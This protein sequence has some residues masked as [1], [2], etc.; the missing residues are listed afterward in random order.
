MP[1]HSLFEGVYVVEGH[2]YPLSPQMY[3][4]KAVCEREG[5]PFQS[6]VD[7]AEKVI[8]AFEPLTD[9]C[10][11]VLIDIWFVNKRVW[12]AMKGRKLHL[13]K[14]LAS[15]SLLALPTRWSRWCKPWRCAGPWK[16]YLL[17]LKS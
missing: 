15:M 6:K 2:Q 3:R 17:I 5:L 8:Q 12:K 9:T 7:L 16:R 11:H 14:R 4:Q 10:T 13:T 1:G